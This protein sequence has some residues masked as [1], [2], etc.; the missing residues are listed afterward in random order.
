[1]KNTKNSVKPADLV[2]F[3]TIVI[4]V[5]LTYFWAIPQ[6]KGLK[7]SID[8]VSL[9][10]QE[11]DAA[12]KKYQTLS[13]LVQD[14][15][16]Y[17]DDLDKFSIAYP[18][19]EQLIEA[20]IQTQILAQKA[21]VTIS[22]L[23]PGA[24]AAGQLPVS[25]SVVGKY[26]AVNTLFKELTTNL[27]PVSIKNYSLTPGGESGGDQINAQLSLNFA[28]DASGATAATATGAAAANTVPN[29]PPSAT[30]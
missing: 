6:T 9:K 4:I 5:S 11:L 12:Q 8:T 18:K 21:G 26:S 30:K 16:K 25:L 7:Q 20:L 22:G 19:S 15:P 1:M 17:K 14:M 10:K 3:G 29:G 24:A 23:T 27:R 28:Y 2:S 13:Q